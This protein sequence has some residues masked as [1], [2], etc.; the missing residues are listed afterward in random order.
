MQRN[1]F[2]GVNHGRLTTSMKEELV[3]DCNSLCNLIRKAYI[4]D[5]LLNNCYACSFD[6][7]KA[8][9]KILFTYAPE[10]FTLLGVSRI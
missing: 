10:D 4:P 6:M 8:L 3:T 7:R 1:A 9:W 2:Q 5:K